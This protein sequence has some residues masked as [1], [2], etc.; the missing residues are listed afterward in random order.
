MKQKVIAL[1][2]IF[3]T[4]LSFALVFLASPVLIAANPVQILITLAIGGAAGLTII[5]LDRR[6]MRKRDNIERDSV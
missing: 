3:T 6:F 2:A 4:A 1:L 5:L